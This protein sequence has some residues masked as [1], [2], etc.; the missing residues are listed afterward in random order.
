MN[1]TCIVSVAF[2]EPYVTHSL[3]QEECLR[4]T[5]RTMN[6]KYFRNMLPIK[7][8]IEIFDIVATFQKSLYGF[9][10]IAIQTVINKGYAK[11]IWLDPCVLPN[12]SMQVLIDALDNHP[13]VVRSGEEPLARM[14]NAKSKK[15]FGV[16][17]E[18]IKDER[19][20]AG[21]IYGFNFNHIKAREV[22]S[23]WK[24]AEEEGIFGTQDDFMAG[25]WSDEACLSLA[26]FKCGV[27]KY[28]EQKFTYLNQ[29]EL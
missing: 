3:K 4:K 17:D 29:K 6:L 10:P 28:W 27:S 15:W 1:K 11:I 26:M 16:T 12:C 22:F 5:N 23:L 7:D 24:Q 14:C 13:I 21:T 18:D 8:G 20:V 2:R 19:T 9:K 25:H